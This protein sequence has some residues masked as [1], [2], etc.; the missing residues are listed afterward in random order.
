M[1]SRLAI[2]AKR[3]EKKKN[4]VCRIPVSNG[5]YGKNQ[6]AGNE[7]DLYYWGDI[8]YMTPG[9]LLYI[10]DDGIACKPKG[11]AGKLWEYNNR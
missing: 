3:L 9:L 6:R 8:G 7:S 11:S 4:L 5:E 1:N 2:D 10:V